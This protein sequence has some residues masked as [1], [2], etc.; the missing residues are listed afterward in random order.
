MAQIIPFPPEH[1]SK[2][3]NIK[4]DWL[5]ASTRQRCIFALQFVLDN[6]HSGEVDP[7][8]MLIICGT[9]NGAE[10]NWLYV[11]LGFDPEDGLTKAMSK[12]LGD[13]EE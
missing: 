6:I 2:D 8:K 10:T 9:C 1:W 11:N 4:S 12:V 3:E 7:T 5:S 13:V